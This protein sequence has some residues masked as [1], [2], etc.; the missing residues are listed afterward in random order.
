M[1][2][3]G[4]LTGARLASTRGDA[5]DLGVEEHSR[6]RPGGGSSPAVRVGAAA[7]VGEEVEAR[8]LDHDRALEQLGQSAADLGHAFPSSTS[9]VKRR[10]ISI[11][12]F[13]APVLGVDDPLEERGHQSMNWTSAAI[14]KRGRSAGPP[15]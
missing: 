6:R 8:V 2:K 13:E 9:S 1:R 4:T 3:G 12:R 11:E 5:L 7:G 10:W 14:V 15:R